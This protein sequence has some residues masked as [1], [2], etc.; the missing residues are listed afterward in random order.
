MND[1][2]SANA[3][4]DARSH[5]KSFLEKLNAATLLAYQNRGRLIAEHHGIEE[6]VLAGGYGYRQILELVQNGADAIL[7][8]HEKGSHSTNGNRIDVVLRDSSLYVANTGSPLTQDGLDALLSSHTSPKRGNEIGRFGLGFKS[9]LRLGGKIDV[10][11]RTSGAIRFDP[12]AC[13]RQIREQFRVQDAPGLRLAWPLEENEAT[14]DPTLASFDWAET[15][16]RVAITAKD[17]EESLRKEIQQFPRE[18]L[19]FLAN[20]VSL[21]LDDGIEPPRNLR[22][23]SNGNERLLW[24]DDESTRW[25]VVS[26]EIVISD[27]RARA[28]ATHIHA[29]QSV[30]LA[31][32]LPVEGKREEAGRFWAFFP[33]HTPTY[34]PGILNAPW[35]LNSDRNAIVGGE[36]NT[37]LMKEAA[38]LVVEALPQLNSADDPA[39]A[40]DAFPR[41]MERTDEDAAPLINHIWSALEETAVIPDASGCLRP[42]VKLWR[43]PRDNADLARK[44]QAQASAEEQIHLVHPSCLEKMRGSRLSAFSDKLKKTESTQPR[45]QKRDVASWFAAVASIERC[46]AMATLE[47]AEEFE[48]DCKKGEWQLL[49]AGLKIIPSVE[50]HLVKPKEVVWAPPGMTVPGRLNICKDLCED[51]NAQHLL[52][53]VMGVQSL[54]DSVWESLLLESLQAVPRSTPE[55]ATDIWTVFWQRLRGAPE[56]LQQKFINLHSSKIRVLRGDGKWVMTDDLLKPGG[57]VAAD[58]NTE[59]RRVLVD[60]TQHEHDDKTLTCLGVFS[61]PPQ[62]TATESLDTFCP[63][64]MHKWRE[65]C[66]QQYKDTHRNPATWSYLEPSRFQ[67]PIG[68]KLLPLLSGS[69]NAKLTKILANQSLSRESAEDLQFGHST[70]HSYPK[71]MVAHPLPWFLLNFGTIQIGEKVISLAAMQSRSQEMALAQF[72]MWQEFSRIIEKWPNVDKVLNPLKPDFREMWQALFAVLASPAALM[73]DS[74]GSLWAGAARDGVIPEQFCSEWGDVPLSEILVT[75]SPDLARHARSPGRIVIT[76]DDVT[77]RLW[78]NKGAINLAECIQAQ[79]RAECGPADRLT[80]CLPELAEVLNA[81][82]RENAV[83]QVVSDLTLKLAVHSERVACLMWKNTLLLDSDQIAHGSRADRLKHV[84]GEV[85]AAGWLNC[86]PGEALKQ[87]GDAGVDERRLRVAEGTTLAERLLLAV[88]NRQEPLRQALGIVGSKDFLQLCTP[89]KLAELTLA[90]L[91]PASLSELKETLAGEGLR[92]PN[93]W[94]SSDARAFVKSLGFPQEF[95]VSATS[96]RQPEERITGPVH[97]P[98][99]HDFQVEVYEEIR[100]LVASGTGRRRA[101][102]SLPTGGGKTR[103]VVEAAVLV[104]LKPEGSQRCVIWVAQTDE[105]CEQA[106][107]AFRQVWLNLGA[108]RTELRIVRL[109]GG[110]PNPSPQELD[111]PIVVVASIQTLN[112]RMGSEALA[113]L[114]PGMVIVDECHYAITPSYTNLLRWLNAEAPRPGQQ[115]KDEPVMIGLSATPFRSDDEESERLARRFDQRWFPGNQAHLHARLRFQGVLSQASYQPMESGAGLSPEEEEA[116]STLW[117]QRDGFQF[118]Q[119]IESINQR[120][121]GDHKRNERLVEYLK[122]T[123]A[124]SI[125]F[126]AN[127]VEHAEE[128]SARLN[129]AGIPAAAVSGNTNRNARRHFLESFKSEIVRVLCNHSL[130]STGFDAPKTDM[131]FIAR[132]VFSPVRYMQMVGRGLRGEK[133]GGTAHCRIVTVM[134]NLGRFQDRHPYHYCQKYFTL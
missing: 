55:S 132:Q 121:A 72:S 46:G 79:W 7:E 19:L 60:P 129:L 89:L 39:R 57:L 58:E 67:M 27:E 28:D 43:H 119:L 81:D 97:L 122:A 29:R 16:V 1:Q 32:A 53:D 3:Y 62:G 109:W 92:P 103:V 87:L 9:L 100:D 134:D 91:G 88:G 110:N 76:L 70:S 93:S 75:A 24:T 26:R 108:Q 83:C 36:W 41:Q 125:L 4:F 64:S 120:L 82:A 45:L 37:A 6:T 21:R 23:E 114:Q 86:P 61:S 34:L 33:T 52:V 25:R 18:F 51:G 124:R 107:E 14:N 63:P 22:V 15:V 11:T 44:W 42:A 85:A 101:V 105:L 126:F 84:I 123:D 49:R 102:V 111:K 2:P 98:P 112:S 30:P 131:V 12:E 78:L 56:S 117:N 20:P 8:A 5:M 35:K 127:S 116:L 77:L 94:S 10:F 69:P 106:V 133:N 31:W 73:D 80:S 99:L 65:L 113:W 13:R 66:R 104:V 47:L 71:I 95:A 90:H 40:L 50:Q 128:M 48:K 38:H 96:R 17:F 59:N 54:D 130:L 68:W 118:D 115:P 74:L